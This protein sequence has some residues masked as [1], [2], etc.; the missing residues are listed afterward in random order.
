MIEPSI[1]N[2]RHVLRGL[3][4][5]PGFSATV[6]LTLAFGIGATVAVFSVVSSVLLKPLPYPAA[7]E[8]VA[9]W[10]KAPGAPGVANG[11]GDLPFSPSLYFTFSE[12]SETLE[13]AGLWNRG[14]ATIT[15]LAEPEQVDL[16]AVTAG[17]L[18]T[19]QVPPLLGRWLDSSDQEPNGPPRA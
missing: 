6:L 16:V 14:A 15:G 5:S 8:I 19:L 11:N 13:S 10:H 2:V 4:N 12:Q 18:E 1:R 7:D 9:I 3:L 17:V